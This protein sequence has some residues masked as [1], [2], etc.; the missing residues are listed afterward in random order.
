MTKEKSIQLFEE[1]CR[2]IPGGVN[3][4]VRAFGSVNE[5]PIFIKEGKGSK[6]VDV[7]NNSYIDYVCSWGPL[8]LGHSSSVALDGM[9][10]VMKRGTTFGMPTEIELKLAKLIVE[11]HR[12]IDKIRMVNSGTEATMSALRLARGYTR[13]SKIMKFEGCYHGHYDGLLVASGSATIKKGVTS[14][15]GI[16]DSMLEDTIVAEFNNIESVTALI[17]EFPD[18]IAAIIIEPIPGNMG[19]VEEHHDFLLDLREVT[20]DHGIVLIFDEVITGFRIGFEGACGHYGITPDLVCFG[21]II[22]GGMPVGAYGGKS[23]IMDELAPLGGVYQAGT[24]SGNPVSMQM[25]YNVIKHLSLNNNIYDS[26]EEL[27]QKLEK[28]YRENLKSLQMTD[29]TLHRIGGMLCQFF[30]QGPIHNYQDVIKADTDH[31]GIYFR[32]MLSQGVLIAPSQYE[33]LFVSAAHSEEDIDYTIKCHYQA[34]ATVK[35]HMKNL[36]TVN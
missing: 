15:E 27:A 6:L 2:Y 32:S 30:A 17:R 26:I 10:E 20:E 23:E 13:R 22:G 9:D 7:D 18:D 36:L 29:I 11:N 8:L 19:L 35:K 24:L 14:S 25:G 31:F 12:A 16:P 4:P 5:T 34:M 33:C 3:S 28:G 21:K 1:S